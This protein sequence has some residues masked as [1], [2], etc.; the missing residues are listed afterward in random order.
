M[1]KLICEAGRNGPIFRLEGGKVALISDRYNYPTLPKPG[2]SPDLARA[3]VETP[4]T[5][6]IPSSHIHRFSPDLARAT[7]ETAFMID[8]TEPLEVVSVPT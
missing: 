8:G 4:G 3:T 2:F 7:V 6:F 5:F 1:L